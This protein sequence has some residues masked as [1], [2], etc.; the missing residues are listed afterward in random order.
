MRV[1]EPPGVEPVWFD[2]FMSHRDNFSLLDDA[3]FNLEFYRRPAEDHMTL[4]KNFW[5]EKEY[6]HRP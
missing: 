5:R 2:V 4:S 3:I 1:N 6:N